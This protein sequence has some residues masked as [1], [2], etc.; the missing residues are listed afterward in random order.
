MHVVEVAVE[1][2]L[3]VAAGYG[4]VAQRSLTVTVLGEVGV[5]PVDDR[6]VQANFQAL[7]TERLEELGDD[8]ASKG[9]LGRF[10]VGGLGVV[11]AE[12]VVMLCGEHG[13]FHAGFTCGARPS[14]G[15]E[16][17]GIELIEVRAIKLLG[18]LLIAANPFAASGD[19]VQTE[20][21]EKAE[22]IVQIPLHAF[23]IPNA[24]KLIGHGDLRSVAVVLCANRRFRAVKGSYL[25]VSGKSTH[26]LPALMAMLKHRKRRSMPNLIQ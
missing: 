17:I 6:V 2:A 16:S 1:V 23:V 3:L 22:A 7:G 20:M 4:V 9:G 19:G 13:I 10:P 8:I 15:V 11:E 12:T 5:V 18:H 21:K 14:A 25:G 26:R 24:V